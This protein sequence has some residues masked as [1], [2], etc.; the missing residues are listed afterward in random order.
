[1]VDKGYHDN[2]AFHLRRGQFHQCFVDK[3][4]ARVGAVKG[5]IGAASTTPMQRH[6]AGEVEPTGGFWIFFGHLNAHL[7]GLA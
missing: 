7:S 5:F 1:M 4:V 3:R 2:R 6:T